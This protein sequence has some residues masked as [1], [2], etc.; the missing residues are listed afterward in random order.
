MSTTLNLLEDLEF[1]ERMMEIYD[2][3]TSIGV[4]PPTDIPLT[5][6]DCMDT[7]VIH[8][9]RQQNS[10]FAPE[11]ILAASRRIQQVVAVSKGDAYAYAAILMAL[12]PIREC[13]PTVVTPS[14]LWWFI[15]FRQR[16]TRT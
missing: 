2:R 7:W 11:V 15:N 6:R 5:S 3:S 1:V 10:T 8:Y 16:I 14:K 13:I 4:L 12:D 9:G